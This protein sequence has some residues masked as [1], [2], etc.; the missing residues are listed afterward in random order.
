MAV[1]GCGYWG[2]NH[3]RNFCELDALEL[4]CDE[5]EAGRA[6][7]KA[8]APDVAITGDVSNVLNS[9]V[10]GVVI[11]TPAGTHY[12]L[13]KEALLAGKDVLVE[14]PLAL[15]LGEASELAALAESLGRILMVGHLL[16]YHPGVVRARELLAEGAIGEV[17]YIYSN[18]LSFG[19]VRQEENALFS[20]APHD[21]AVILRLVGGSPTRVSATGGSFV[22]EGIE[23][24]TLTTLEFER[25]VKGHIFVSWLHPFKEQRLVIVG[26]RGMLSF[27][28]V[29]KELTLSNKHAVAGSDGPVQLGE[30]V[31]AIDFGDGEPLRLECLAFLEAIESRVAPLTDGASGLEVLRVL[32]AAQRS[33]R[34]GGAAVGLPLHAPALTAAPGLG[35]AR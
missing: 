27:D 26:E 18:R 2:R 6:A 33:L 4:V 34:A 16:E 3:V 9:D 19:K 22:T 1:I 5:S 25:G 23:D 10:R 35:G 21:V 30:K 24:V 15:D 11:A 13:A 32:A 8:I 31:E 28:D 7:A 29:N 12:R 14:K 20:L 17:R